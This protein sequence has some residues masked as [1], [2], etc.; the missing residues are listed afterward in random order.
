MRIAD[1]TG[2]APATQCILRE[3]VHDRAAHA[4]LIGRPVH[5]ARARPAPRKILPP[6]MTTVLRAQRHIAGS[7]FTR[8]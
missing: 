2:R 3:R 5:Y 1:I 4:H 7:P 8:L 6:P